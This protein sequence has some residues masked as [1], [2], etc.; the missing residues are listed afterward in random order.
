MNPGKVA[1]FPATLLPGGWVEFE[2]PAGV[3]RAYG[4]SAAARLSLV[5]QRSLL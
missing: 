1:G 5:I 3:F 4:M 2:T